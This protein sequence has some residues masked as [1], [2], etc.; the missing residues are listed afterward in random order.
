VNVLRSIEQKIE[1][2]FEGLFGR[3]FRANVQP[4][5]L[6]RKLVVEMD[7]HRTVSVSRIYVPNEYTVYLSS[8][9]REQ[10]ADYESSLTVELRDYL[11]EHA[12]RE[13]YVLLTPPVVLMETDDDLSIGEFGIATRMVQRDPS[14]REPE[15]APQLESG[16]TMVYRP[17]T[18]LP[19]EGP[20]ADVAVAQEI[21]TLT[22]DGIRHEVDKR[23]FVLG[24]SK[25][26][27]V[28]LTD[29]NVSRRHAELRQEGL[30]YWLIDLDSTNGSQVNGQ[31]TARSKLESG[32]TITIGS[33]DLVF[34]RRL[35]E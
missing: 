24:R 22:M 7:D 18:P 11:A 21:V 6:A 19:V 12:R 35:A 28:Q 32:D 27:D 1:G 31:R 2:L 3:A 29:P 17:R 20:P 25:E 33:T 9:D 4:V 30:A 16:A 5:E 10:F 15:P 8:A 23:R 34:E 26:C 13:G 14:S